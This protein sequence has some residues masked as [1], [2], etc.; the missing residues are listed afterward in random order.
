MPYSRPWTTNRCRCVPVQ[1]KAICST[2][3]R[4]AIVVS[5]GSSSCRQISGLT[6][7]TTTRSWYTLGRG[8]GCMVSGMAPI[9]APRTDGPGQGAS[10]G[11]SRSRAETIVPGHGAVCGPDVINQ[12]RDY[13]LFVQDIARRGV[14]AGIDPLEAARQTDLGGYADLLD[15]ERIVGNLHRA[16]LLYTSP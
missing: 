8:A 4:P 12:V 11:L 16:C 14:E 7:R 3:C 13:L 9:L 6:P 1:P 2:A 10:H 15:A 5:A